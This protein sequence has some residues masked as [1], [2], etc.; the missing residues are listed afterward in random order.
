MKLSTDVFFITCSDAKVKTIFDKTKKRCE[1]VEM[2]RCENV[3]MWRC[4]DV[5]MWRCGDV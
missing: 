3:E 1:N 5:E 2:W 4:G